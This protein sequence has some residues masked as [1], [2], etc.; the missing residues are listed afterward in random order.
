[1]KSDLFCH[2]Q[3]KDNG[4]HLW[5]WHFRCFSSK[6]GYFPIF[7]QLQNTK[8]ESMVTCTTSEV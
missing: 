2:W 3:T 7:L 5:P 1:M 6:V 4:I 8:F